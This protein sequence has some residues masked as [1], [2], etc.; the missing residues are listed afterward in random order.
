MTPIS[1]PKGIKNI[2]TKNAVYTLILIDL[3]TCNHKCSFTHIVGTSLHLIGSLLMGDSLSTSRICYST[4]SVVAPGT[5]CSSSALNRFSGQFH[6][7]PGRQHFFLNREYFMFSP[8]GDSTCGS[9]SVGDLTFFGGQ[10]SR[11]QTSLH[12]SS[13]LPCPSHSACDCH[14]CV[15]EGVPRTKI[16]NRIIKLVAKG[17]EYCLPMTWFMIFS[18]KIDSMLKR[19]VS[20]S[21]QT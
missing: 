1:F 16:R 9:E 13:A 10:P 15:G 4:W 12:N 20:L 18:I 8:S 11:S 21:S 6:L 19:F 3:K 7:Q 14:A 17:I 2:K 5:T